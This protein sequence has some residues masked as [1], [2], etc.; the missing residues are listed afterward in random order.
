MRIFV[1]GRKKCFQNGDSFR[2]SKINLA[3]EVSWLIQFF[4]ENECR[5]HNFALFRMAV[6]DLLYRGLCQRYLKELVF[7]LGKLALV[8]VFIVSFITLTVFTLDNLFIHVF[9]EN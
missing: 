6:S 7:C 3:N 5:M 4:F 2:N 9:V 8:H 1:E